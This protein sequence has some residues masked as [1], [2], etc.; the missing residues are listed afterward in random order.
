MHRLRFFLPAVFVAAVLL[1]PSPAPAQ[2]AEIKIDVDRTIGEVDS[3]IY[4]NFVEH[5]GRNVYG[6]I[7][8]PDSPLSNEQGFRTDVMQATKDLNVSLMRYPGGN[9]VSNYHWKDGVGEERPNRLELA[10][11]RIETN[12]FGTNEFMDFADSVDTEPYFA[13]NLGTGTIEEAQQWVEYTN[14]EG[15]T[16]YSELRKQHGHEEPYDIKYWSLGNEMD[17]YWQIGHL[18]AEDYSKKAREA[19]K[20]MTRTDPDISLVAAG[21]SNFRP[22]ANPMHWNRIVLEELRD[23]VDY[24][25]LHIYVGNPN[26]NY[27]NFQSTPHVMEQRTE[28]VEG[29]IDIAMQDAES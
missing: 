24:I 17:G 10:W 2:N 20:M 16:Y 11:S 27:Y 13:V 4:G 15:G 6:G 14:Y 21:A 25:A 5:L 23:V 9:F 7:Y 26:D 3:L 18:N 29:L 1:V 19:A 8:D 28:L 22:D 12:E